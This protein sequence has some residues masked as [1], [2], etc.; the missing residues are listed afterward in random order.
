VSIGDNGIPVRFFFDKWIWEPEVLRSLVILGVVVPLAVSIVLYPFVGE[1]ALWGL[2]A[3][4]ISLVFRVI[5][6]FVGKKVAALAESMPSGYGEPVH[7]LIV[8][9]II[10]APGLA[11]I[12]DDRIVLAPIVGDRIVIE[13]SKI[14][15][16]QQ[17]QFFNGKA[18]PG[19]TGFWFS[20]PGHK[21][22]GA[23]V[24]N[25]SADAWRGHLGLQN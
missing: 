16:V 10:Q 6:G 2:L 14:Q 5:Y 8:N 18:V 23:A 25:L 12:S 11:T 3:A 24:S 20:V 7:A 19:K 21:R 9:G 1:W 4:G 22:L 17:T 13:L 15:S